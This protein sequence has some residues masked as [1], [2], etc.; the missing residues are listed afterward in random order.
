MPISIILLPYLDL[1]L[2]CWLMLVLS[3][4]FALFLCL[5]PGDDHSEQQGRRINP[6]RATSKCYRTSEP[7]GGFIDAA[8]IGPSTDAVPNLLTRRILKKDGRHAAPMVG[9]NQAG[10]SHR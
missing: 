1:L 8:G 5:A 2:C 4:C 6:G 3:G 10:D 9:D 7:A